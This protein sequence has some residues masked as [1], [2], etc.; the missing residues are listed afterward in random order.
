MIWTAERPVDPL[1]AHPFGDGWLAHVPASWPAPTAAWLAGL[2]PDGA[3][4]IAPLDGDGPAD[5]D[6]AAIRAVRAWRPL[7]DEARDDALVDRLIAPGAIDVHH[8][9][10][11]GI[12]SGEVFGYE[13][14]ARPRA[15]RIEPADAIA[16]AWGCGRG[17]E[18]E[19]AC[20][21]AALLRARERPPGTRLFVNL[22]APTMTALASDVLSALMT[23]TDL[24]RRSLVIEI[25]EQEVVADTRRLVERA[26]QL[27]RRGVEIALDDTGTGYS[28]FERIAA[29]RPDYVKLDKVLVRGSDTDRARYALLCALTDLGRQIGARVI[30]EGVETAHELGAVVR[31]GVCLAQGFGFARPGPDYPASSGAL[32]LGVGGRRR[33][34][35]IR[36]S[37]IVARDLAGAAVGVPHDERA[38]EAVKRF[39]RDPALRTLVVT[40]P[41]GDLIGVVTRECLAG[42]MSQMYGPAL[43]GRRPVAE[44]C[45]PGA[46]VVEEHADI[47]MVSEQAMLRSQERMYDDVVVTDGAGHVRGMVVVRDLL[48]SLADIHTRRARD[49][50]PLTGLPGNVLIQ[51]AIHDRVERDEEF[52]VTHVDLDRFKN[53]NDWAGL[54]EGDRLIVRLAAAIEAAWSD[55]EDCL[56][57]HVGGDDFIVVAPPSVAESAAQRLIETVEARLAP[58]MRTVIS[59]A[60]ASD[61]PPLSVSLATL[62]CSPPAPA[63]STI[64]ARL[65]SL[66]ADAKAIPGSVH[67]MASSWQVDAG[68]R[69]GPRDRDR[70]KDVRATRT[71]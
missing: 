49:L 26:A 34:H 69:P 50:N 11:V 45:D 38:D 47:V 17:T 20:L 46:L 22:S 41:G 25:T 68:P 65:A 29:V 60:G 3:A 35:R 5:L 52:A 27:R 63:P 8:Q 9:P 61:A 31:A 24:E 53:V 19:L 23:A 66:K 44:L 14:L 55:E 12:A 32:L 37:G 36:G 16:R 30:A 56:V 6:R 15:L 70:H 51:A 43:H 13:A 64:F 7:R 59:S 21:R 33:A 39:H 62:A 10:I 58:E 1:R 2:S 71:T 54:A 48:G 18:L 40:D 57:G 42:L 4:G 67:R 28:T